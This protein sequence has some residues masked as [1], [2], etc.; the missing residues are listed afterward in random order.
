MWANNGG[1][2]KKEESWWV[3]QKGYIEGR[4]TLPDGTKRSVKQLRYIAEQA[5]GRAILPSEDVHHRDGVK[6]NNDPSNF[7][8]LPH[9]EHS[10]VTN[11]Q[12]EYRRGYTLRISDEERRARS[13]RMSEMRRNGRI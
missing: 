13:E 12:R 11:A 6:T 9:A 8:V 2:N 10:R 4:V 3:N 5:L 1:Q 7:D